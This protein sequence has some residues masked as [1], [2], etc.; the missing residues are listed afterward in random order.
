MYEGEVVTADNTDILAKCGE[1][2]FSH[3]WQRD[4]VDIPGATDAAYELAKTDIGC[5]IRVVTTFVD[6]DG[7]IETF[8][9][10]DV[11][12]IQAAVMEA[13]PPAP[14]P[15]PAPVKTPGRRRFV[16]KTFTIAPEHVEALEAR[17]REA[18]I[19]G[20]LKRPDVSQVVRQLLDGALGL[21]QAS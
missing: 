1:G 5:V 6:A 14:A 7:V 8:A 18:Y 12:P 13:P 20:Q 2:T 21:R 3:Q 4:G 15:V 19:S 16:P 9:S 10:G 11:G 17:A